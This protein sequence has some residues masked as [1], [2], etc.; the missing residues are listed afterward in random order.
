MKKK[1]RNLFIP[2]SLGACITCITIIGITSTFSSCLNIE[3]CPGDDYPLY[4]E[5]VKKCCPADKPYTD[6]HGSC[7]GTLEACRQTGYTCE[8]C[9][10]E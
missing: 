8:R 9:W 3:K 4:C 5:G 2:I 6:G 7:W 1:L 10:E